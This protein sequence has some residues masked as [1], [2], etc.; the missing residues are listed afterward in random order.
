MNS[1]L[2]K[3]FLIAVTIFSFSYASAA[4][5]LDIVQPE[6]V[7]FSSEQLNQIESFFS[8]R[9]EKGEIAGIVT[10]VARHGKIAHFSAVGYQDVEKGILMQKD[11]LF[12]IYSMTKPIATTAL[13]M[14]YQDGLFQMNDPLSK[15][16]PEFANLRVLREPGAPLDET[17][18]LEREPTVQDILRHTAGFS[19]GLGTSDY[20]EHF[21]DDLGIFSPETSLTEMML[22][23]SQ[24]PLVNQPG[25]QFR[26]SVGPDVALRLVEILSG[27]SADDYLEERMFEPLGM[28]DTG[29][30]VDLDNA[31][32]LSPIHWL[33]EGELVP[34]DE[35]HGQPVGG[36]LVQ[37]WSANSYTVDHEFKGG[38]LGL[39]STAED[40]FRFA[41]AMLDGGELNGERLVSPNVVEFMSRNHLTEEQYN[42]FA[43][44]LGFGLGFAVIDDPAQVGYP[45]S[46]GTFYW[47]GAAA[48]TFWIDPVEDIVVVS[49]TQHMRVPGTGS[50][51]GELSALV[52]GALI[53]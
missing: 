43:P 6:E 44:G 41:Q 10:L 51:R 46:E 39:V 35:S 1:K 20:D 45:A 22:A 34:L 48:T 3:I 8:N 4:D 21:V 28:G 37:P 9:V 15:F 2:L 29:Y 52:Y 12:R 33:K 30:V 50:I 13:M 5:T 26:Y 40:Y 23:L 38:S 11:T 47:G 25:E 53:E 19:H 17:I 24:I 49:M 36:V 31:H 18:A 42:S 27:M 14:L 32:R 16:I 7:G